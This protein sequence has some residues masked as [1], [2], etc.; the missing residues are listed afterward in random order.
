MGLLNTQ[1]NG[2]YA[3]IQPVIINGA[4][5]VGSVSSPQEI[6][7]GNDHFTC[8]GH[9]IDTTETLHPASIPI[10]SGPGAITGTTNGPARAVSDYSKI[11]QINNK[12]VLISATKKFLNIGNCP[13]VPMVS[14]TSN[15][16]TYSIN[17]GGNVNSSGKRFS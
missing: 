6:I 3:S 12:C 10:P 7:I 1:K 5:V 16:G 8:E 14:A 13:I 15:K 2:L 4:V 11:M 17:N 9:A